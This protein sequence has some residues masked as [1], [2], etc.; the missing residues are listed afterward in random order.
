M[1]K[2]Y[3]RRVAVKDISRALRDSF[4]NVKRLRQRALEEYVSK[5]ATKIQKVWRGWFLRTRVKPIAVRRAFY[6]LSLRGRREILLKKVRAVV[7]GWRVR[8]IMRT[9]EI[10]NLAR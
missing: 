7:Q 3:Q 4:V 6:T 1:A 2:N 5:A 8:K 9:K 10:A